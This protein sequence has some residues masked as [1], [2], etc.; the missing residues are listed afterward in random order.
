MIASTSIKYQIGI[1]L[2]GKP[3]DTLNI[4]F[5]IY[6]VQSRFSM[7]YKNVDESRIP[8]TKK[9]GP[10][11]R[12]RSLL[13]GKNQNQNLKPKALCKPKTGNTMGSPSWTARVGAIST[14]NSRFGMG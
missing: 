14:N 4:V 9:N 13:V 12:A 10:F 5:F 7:I 1:A 3:G 8:V 2:I 6:K 11:Y